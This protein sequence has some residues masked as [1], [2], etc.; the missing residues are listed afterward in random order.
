MK[1]VI[2]VGGGVAGMQ[3]AIS[4]SELGLKAIIVEKSDKL[5]GKLNNWYKL[6]PSFTSAQSV[7]DELCEQI[8]QLSIEVIYNSYAV[9][10][11]PKSITLSSGDTMQCDATVICNGF[12]LFDA[13]IK[14][15]YGYGL[16]NN[17]ITSQEL[18]SMFKESSIKD[19]FGESPKRIALLHCVGSRDEK[20][21][22]RHCSKVCCITGVKQAIEL[23]ELYPECEIFNFYMDIRMFG[24]GFEQLYRDAQVNHN[25]HF[26]RGRISEASETFDG[27]IQIKSEDTLIGRPLRMTVDKLILLV[28]M[29]SQSENVELAQNPSI[30]FGR[31]GFLEPKDLFN[32]SC[33][34]KCESIFYAGTATSPKTVGESLAEGNRAAMQVAKFLR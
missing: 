10:V 34:S 14:E 27:R 23:K 11:D 13:R 21:N 16:Y 32:N 18:E 9:K 30:E 4:L 25:V 20:V 1:R 6:F 33:N 28:G 3:T 26:I 8:K 12:K 7:V 2:I 24:L 5:G 17:V 19:N 31:G 22:Q 15:E 29:C